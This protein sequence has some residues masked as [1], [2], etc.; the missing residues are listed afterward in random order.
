MNSLLSFVYNES[1]IPN[2]ECNY[3]P[4][5]KGKFIF[6]KRK[7]NYHDFN[8]QIKKRNIFWCLHDDC[9]EECEPFHSQLELDNHMQEY[10]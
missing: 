8:I 4:T 10:H 3:V 1:L 6:I 2:I 5:S 9:L 7:I